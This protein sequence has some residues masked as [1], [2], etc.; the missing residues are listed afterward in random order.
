MSGGWRGPLERV[1]EFRWRIPVTYKPGMRVPGLIYADE[2]HIDGIREDQAP[3][4]VA[5]AAFLPGMVGMSLAMPDIHWGY[6]FAIGG[7]GATLADCGVISPG[8]VGFDINC[9][10]RM[11]RTN[12]FK[13][14]VR[15]HLEQLVNQLFRDIPSGVGSTGVIKLRRDETAEV[16]EKGALWAVEKGYGWPRDL[17]HTE[18]R[19][20]MSGARAEKVSD[21]AVKRGMPQ[22]GTLGSGN[23]F[24]EVQVVDEVYDEKVAERFG[25]REGQIVVMIHSGSRGLGHQVCTDHLA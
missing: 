4:Q 1:D 16:L 22:L 14:D 20:C 13:Q 7:V 17:D 9:G 8:G 19:G 2:K 21:R 15:P 23:H 5:N 12:L 6:G 11:L 24:L 3:E 10:V 25:L 18:E